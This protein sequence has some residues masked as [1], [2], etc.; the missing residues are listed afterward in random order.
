MR[1]SLIFLAL[2]T[3][4]LTGCNKEADTAN[5][6]VNAKEGTAATAPATTATTDAASTPAPESVKK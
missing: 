4:V 2:I 5:S 1:K 6:T 3:L